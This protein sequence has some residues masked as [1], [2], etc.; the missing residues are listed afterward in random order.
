MSN[1]KPT[2]RTL[3]EETHNTVTQLRTVLLGVPNTDDRGLVGEVKQ[4]KTDVNEVY[5][6]NNKEI[7]PVVLITPSREIPWSNLVD[8]GKM[9]NGVCVNNEISSVYIASCDHGHAHDPDGPY[10][11]HPASKVFDDQI[12]SWIK[13]SELNKILTL[14]P[15]F[16][17]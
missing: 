7:P 2:N 6:K 12:V 10:G 8:L 1:D 11:Y 5:K 4:I 15:E 3:L 9:I 13:N 17:D 14:S 16:I